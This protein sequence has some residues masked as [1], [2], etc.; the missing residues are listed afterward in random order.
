MAT[1]RPPDGGA[2]LRSGTTAPE[3]R[4]RPSLGGLHEKVN[5]L[6]VRDTVQMQGFDQTVAQNASIGPT[7][8]TRKRGI[9]VEFQDLPSLARRASVRR[10]DQGPDAAIH[11]CAECGRMRH[12]DEELASQSLEKNDGLSRRLAHGPR[13]VGDV[14]ICP[15]GG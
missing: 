10:S 1:A 3:R 14:M 8:P 6:D 9:H 12:G 11:H 7:S 2:A 15:V 13:H 4:T 5:E